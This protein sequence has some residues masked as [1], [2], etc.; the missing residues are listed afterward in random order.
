MPQVPAG[1]RGER[2]RQLG[3]DDAADFVPVAVHRG[4][5]RAEGAARGGRQRR[6]VEPPRPRIVA[7]VTRGRDAPEGGDEAIGWHRGA[8]GQ[9]RVTARR[10]LDPLDHPA[11][12]AHQAG[13]QQRRVV[14]HPAEVLRALHRTTRIG[15]RGL[16]IARRPDAEAVLGAREV[17]DAGVRAGNRVA[18]A[19]GIGVDQRGVAAVVL[20]GGVG[21]EDAQPAAAGVEA[22][23]QRVLGA[24]LRIRRGLVGEREEVRHHVVAVLRVL[25][26]ALVELAPHAA[27]HVG[28][29]AVEGLAP[30]LV[31]VE[32]LVDQRAQQPPGLRA[33]VGIGP[34]QAAGRRVA[35]GR[36]GVLEP[37][38][39][40]AEHGH[41]E[42]LH[43]RALRG[44][45]HLVEPA[46]LEAALEMDVAGVRDDATALA[47]GEAPAPARDRGGRAIGLIAHGEERARLREVRGRIRHV[48]AIG[49]QEVGHRSGGL[50]LG[51]DAAAQRTALRVP[52]LRRAHADETGYARQ[53]PL[54][55]ARDDD[56]AALHQEAVAH[57]DRR[58]RV[59]SGGEGGARRAVEV[60]HRHRVAAVD[61]IQQDTPRALGA[62]HRQQDRHVRIPRDPPGRVARGQR[63]VGDAE[64]RRV[65]RIDREVQPPLQ[66]LV[67]R[68]AGQRAA[69]RDVEAGDRH[70]RP[71]DG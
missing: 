36:A 55:A 13:A 18:L 30:L 11:I 42:A 63:H 14:H 27:G 28:D 35:L 25:A 12:E 15:G 1:V 21:V 24:G 7:R 65:E 52:R 51:V 8:V 71:L 67:A 26:E 50:H 57:V 23:V 10:R 61:D 3:Q 6:P 34:P 32:V 16:A 47:P 31:Q 69:Q 45:R 29:D 54:P 43:R 64:V 62:I 49:E 58:V 44:V 22:R 68:E 70:G 2:H 38:D 53:V 4:D 40:V 46:L 37:S 17:I 9:A 5:E 19:V 56:P 60:G 48:A 66:L 39:R 59:R 33:A 41:R 20:G